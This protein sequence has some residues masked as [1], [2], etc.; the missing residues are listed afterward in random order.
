MTWEKVEGQVYSGKISRKTID[1]H[2]MNI[3]DFRLTPEE[4]VAA[5]DKKN[6]GHGLIANA[7][8]DETLRKVI[9]CLEENVEQQ[10]GIPYINERVLVA[11]KRMVGGESHEKDTD[12]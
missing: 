11:L 1:V 8:T 4:I 9:E 5:I 6:T 7:A 10:W 2:Q 12:R 3:E